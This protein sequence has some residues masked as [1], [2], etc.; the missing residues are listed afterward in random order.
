MRST[1][2]A[3]DSN[4]Q[5]VDPSNEF[6][7]LLAEL[8]PFEIVSQPVPPEELPEV[9]ATSNP[10]RSGKRS[11]RLT[12]AK[13]ADA[14]PS[15]ANLVHLV[16]ARFAAEH[17]ANELSDLRRV[18][19]R[20]IGRHDE[21]A[22][23]QSIEVLLTSGEAGVRDELA[24]FDCTSDSVGRYGPDAICSMDEDGSCFV[25]D[26]CAGRD[27]GIQKR[28]CGVSPMSCTVYQCFDLAPFETC[29]DDG[30]GPCVLPAGTRPVGERCDAD[31]QCESGLCFG[32]VR[33]NGWFEEPRCQPAGTCVALYERASY[34]RNDRHCC[35][36]TCCVGCGEREGLCVEGP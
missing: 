22:I 14:F 12:L 7:L 19:D 23:V 31:D 5:P 28:E 20:A 13:K 6:S 3:V 25:I 32:A 26:D 29:A 8:G 18:L 21:D 9:Q 11:E 35:E 1:H 27:G 10:L 34:C 4:G 17:R 36:G 30:Q 33:P 24:A 2:L 16:E 15:K